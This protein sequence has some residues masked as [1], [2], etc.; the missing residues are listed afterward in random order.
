MQIFELSAVGM[1]EDVRPTMSM[2]I[3]LSDRQDAIINKKFLYKHN[4]CILRNI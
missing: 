3:I 1:K 2:V 4:K